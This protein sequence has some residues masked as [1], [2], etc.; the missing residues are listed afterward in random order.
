MGASAPA[1]AASLLRNG[2]YMS[3]CFAVNEGALLAVLSLRHAAP[4]APS[5]GAPARS[6]P[7]VAV[8]LGLPWLRSAPAPLMCT[9][10]AVSPLSLP[11]P[12]LSRLHHAPSPPPPPSLPHTGPHPARRW[13]TH[14]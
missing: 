5:P 7:D 1:Q 14:S 2:L 6:A 10:S 3:C 9:A 13:W 8:P 12:V 4:A 11:A